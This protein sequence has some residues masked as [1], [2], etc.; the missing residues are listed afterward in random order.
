MPVVAPPH[1]TAPP[2]G[3]RPAPTSPAQA[4]RA[5]A[6]PGVGAETASTVALTV[7]TLAAV[8]CMRRLFQTWDYFGPVASAAIATHFVSWWLRRVRLPAVLAA[9]GPLAVFGLV[10]AWVQVPETTFY[11][12]PT[13]DT[14]HTAWRLLHQ[15]LDDFHT[16]VAPAPVTRGFIIASILGAVIV[17]GLADW[18]AYRMHAVVEATIP[19]FGMFIFVAALATAKGRVL[20]TALE[21]AAIIGFLLVHQVATQSH[22]AGWVA[23]RSAGAASSTLRIG[24]ALGALAALVGVV[25]GPNLPGATS[26]SLVAWRNK[27]PNGDASRSTVSPLVDIRGRLVDRAQ[28][29]VFTVQSAARAYWRLTSLDTFDGTIWSSNESYK[30]IKSTLSADT[31]AS[32]F[33]DSTKVV[34]LFTIGSLDS[35]WLPAAYEPISVSGIKKVSYSSESGSLISSKETTNGLKYSVTSVLPQLTADQLKT[36]PAIDV[37]AMK[38]YLALPVIPADVRNLATRIVRNKPTEYAKA[39]A[40][41]DYL[42]ANYTYSTDVSLGHGGSAIEQFLL[43]PDKKG[44]CEQ[45]AGSYAVLARAV[46]LPTRIAV[47]FTAG[48]P[49]DQGTLHVKDEHAHAWPE[50]YF[51]N[52][53]WVPFEPTPGRGVPGATAY[54]GVVDPDAPA[55][56]ASTTPT[57]QATTG[58]SAVS[59]PTSTTLPKNDKTLQ[60]GQTNT[61]KDRSGLVTALGILALL[62]LLAVAWLVGVPALRRRQ[63]AQRWRSARGPS[64]RVLLAWEDANEVLSLAGAGRRPAETYA[65]HARRVGPSPAVGQPAS[66]AL[67]SLAR[68]ATA[69]RYAND[70]LPADVAD[71]AARAAQAVEDAVHAHETRTQRLLRAADPRSLIASKP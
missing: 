46:G 26:T 10:T 66:S 22:T 4:R 60:D 33:D 11:G 19:S 12:V 9:L 54:T 16:M 63:R 49:D 15:S 45:F 1:P 2:N 6:P 58:S 43:G 53:G 41:Q 69:A 70:E 25:L 59:S 29:E 31:S 56:P 7:L 32:P 5:T 61:S 35:I 68:D 18:A 40:I 71:R 65:E 23:N 57:T 38:R 48:S 28:T 37:A 42:R 52:A 51:T 24:V 17:A 30:S 62:L 44:Y 36:S 47:G 64:D 14:F 8:V 50:V 39:K 21:I 27:S 20:A 34:Q 67:T 3:S 13:S 55:Q